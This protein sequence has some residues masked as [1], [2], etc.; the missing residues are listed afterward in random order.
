MKRILELTEEDIDLHVYEGIPMQIDK[1]KSIYFKNYIRE[2]WNNFDEHWYL[3]GD[4]RFKIK[5][6]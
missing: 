1:M 6:Q 5:R 2:Q 4:A 3:V